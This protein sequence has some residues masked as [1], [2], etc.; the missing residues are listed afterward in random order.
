MPI[1]VVCPGCKVRFSVSEKF[2]G[3]RGPCPKCKA[4]ILVPTVSAPEVK[5]AEPEQYASAG[6]DS[7]GRPVSK[8]IARK[9]TKFRLRAALQI[10]GVVLAVFVVAWVIGRIPNTAILK[11]FLV[12]LGLLA[13]SPPLVIAGYSFLHEPELEPYSGKPLW[14]RGLIC[15]SIYAVLWGV[16]MLIPA[17]FIDEV[18]QW[19]VVAPVFIGLGAVAA[20]S[21]L[22][23]DYGSG[24]VHYMFYLIATLSLRAA[25]GLPAIWAKA[26]S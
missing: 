1:A 10:F 16:F 20:W 11:T 19:I 4:I 21:T 22:D 14:I 12:A 26:K 5:I 3:K 7:Q 24:S 15:A 18:W 17:D 25:A 23:L 9:E 8:P 2:A 13:V 6:K